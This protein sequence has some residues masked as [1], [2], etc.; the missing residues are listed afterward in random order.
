MF[1]VLWWRNK[2]F[3]RQ[4]KNV[5]K[6]SWVANMILVR[7]KWIS[8]LVWYVKSEGTNLEG[9]PVH[10]QKSEEFFTI[11]YSYFNRNKIYLHGQSTMVRAK[12]VAAE[13]SEHC[14]IK[15]MCYCPYSLLRSLCT[16][17]WH[18]EV[19]QIAKFSRK[20][21]PSHLQQ[22]KVKFLLVLVRIFH[23]VLF[24]IHWHRLQAW[25]SVV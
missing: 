13:Y 8:D 10:V 16:V 12:R 9:K 5:P 6:Y 17:L 3:D 23:C 19:W 11:I 25:N 22:N 1:C 14:R 24:I 20:V 15:S 7:N 18:R 4:N 2:P 21:Q